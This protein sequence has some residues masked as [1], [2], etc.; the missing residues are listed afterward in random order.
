ML[1]GALFISL[2]NWKQSKAL[3][4]GQNK[5]L[6]CMHIIRYHW[7]ITR[8]SNILCN[9]KAEP[10]MH[11]VKSKK[12]PSEASVQGH[13]GKVQRT[14]PWLA[15]VGLIT[16]RKPR[17]FW[18][19]E[20]VVYLDYG[21]GYT[22]LYICQKSELYV[23]NSDCG[24]CLVVQWLRICLSTQGTWVQFLVQELRSHVLWRN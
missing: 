12:P 4:F 18:G 6:W 9:K 24:T 10:Q 22:T 3:R 17:E 11:Y 13:C 20:T 21:C 2:K 16:N 15:E 5:T 1:I 19:D 8:M 23:K 7:A 14:D